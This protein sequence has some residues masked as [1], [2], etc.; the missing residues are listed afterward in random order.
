MYLLALRCRPLY[1]PTA[2]T[3]H[4]SWPRPRCRSVRWDLLPCLAFSIRSH[5][6]G[7]PPLAIALALAQLGGRGGAGLGSGL[8]LG[9]GL[10]ALA[11]VVGAEWPEG[12]EVLLGLRPWARLSLAELLPL[13][14]LAAGAVV[15]L[16]AGAA[17][18][19]RALRRLGV[20]N[21]FSG[22]AACCAAAAVA[23]G[24][25]LAHPALPLVLGT[26]VLGWRSAGGGASDPQ[27]ARRQLASWH[28]VHLALL[29]LPLSWLG[30]W[31]L[32]GRAY[33]YPWGLARGLLALL[34]VHACLLQPQPLQGWRAGAAAAASSGAA[35]ATALA[36][37]WGHPH[38]ALYAVAAAVAA[39][40]LLQGWPAGARKPR[41]LREPSSSAS[42]N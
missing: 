36:G 27:Q 24:S 28:A 3:N 7:V 8:G 29:P 2:M 42:S 1:P 41:G 25:T 40:A 22:A 12:A 21:A 5:A 15:A 32:S 13:L 10:V 39:H 35:A 30:G 14:A 33:P 34:G 38:P 20:A 31:L 26:A 9:L 37:L 17:A 18:G 4:K 23:G 16:E 6:F 11:A 19:R